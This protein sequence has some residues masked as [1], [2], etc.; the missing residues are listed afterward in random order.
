MGLCSVSEA[1]SAGTQGGKGPAHTGNSSS[2]LLFFANRT[3]SVQRRGLTL[4]STTA[5]R[6]GGGLEVTR[7]CLLG[8]KAAPSRSKWQRS[9]LKWALMH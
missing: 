7:R 3:R 1:W 2:P 5:G 6:P 9:W 4:L 8:G